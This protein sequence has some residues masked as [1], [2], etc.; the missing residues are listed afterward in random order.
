MFRAL[1]QGQP[2]AAH[3]VFAQDE[4]CYSHLVGISPSAQDHLASYALYWAEIE[5]FSG[6][7]RW[8]DWG[9]AAGVKD[10]GKGGLAQFKRG[11]STGTRPAY[12]CGRIFQK[13]IYDEIVVF[14][15]ANNT[16][17]FPAYRN[18]EFK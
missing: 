16:D 14:S 8:F 7:A 10:D 12:F 17:Y 9:A 2:V 1:H 11:W 6:K 5:Y 3:L 18:G 15:G 13:K 4:V